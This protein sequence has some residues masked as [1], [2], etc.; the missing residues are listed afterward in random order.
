MA[1]LKMLASLVLPVFASAYK[2]GDSTLILQ[3]PQKPSPEIQSVDS[4]LFCYSIELSYL[5]D[6]AGNLRYTQ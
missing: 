4:T 6:Y 2:H 3:I 1:C 5:V